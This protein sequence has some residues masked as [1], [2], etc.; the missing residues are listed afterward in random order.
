M[1][2]QTGSIITYQDL[3][4]LTINTIKTTCQNINNIDS[5]VPAQLKNGY[6]G[7]SAKT[8]TTTGTAYN[9]V[10]FTPQTGNGYLKWLLND[11]KLNVVP[12]ET[13]V[14]QLNSFLSSRGIAAR[15]GTVMTTR[16]IL[17][18]MANAA[19]FISCKVIQIGSN[20]TSTIVTYYDQSASSYPT[21]TSD[22]NYNDTDSFTPTNLTEML[23]NLNSTNKFHTAV[24]SYSVS[25]SSSSSSSCSSSCSSSSSSSSSSSVFIAYMKL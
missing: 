18:F 12:E 1:A 14:N 8:Y 3:V 11:S 9:G 4:D 21:V 17:N 15:A 20:D 13:V 16:G 10:G 22:L 6:T 25:C 19:A 7:S 2:I 23:N 5:S 24:Y